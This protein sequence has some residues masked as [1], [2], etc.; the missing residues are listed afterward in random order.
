MLSQYSDQAR[1]WTTVIPF[2]AG[3]G[4]FPLHHRIQT[5][6]LHLS[7]VST[8]QFTS[9]HFIYLKPVLIQVP[10]FY[11]VTPVVLW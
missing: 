7:R 1:A 8:I 2:L 11:I 10:V 5:G 3:V 4:I 9:I 6:Y